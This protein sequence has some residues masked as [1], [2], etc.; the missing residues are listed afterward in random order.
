MNIDQ[1]VCSATA[2]GSIELRWELR[3]PVQVTDEMMIFGL[4]PFG[5]EFDYVADRNDSHEPIIID[6]GHLGNVPVAHLRHDFLDIIA[7]FAP[8]GIPGHDF[9]N[10]HGAKRF[11]LDMKPTKDVTLAEDPK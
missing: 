5:H 2:L 8:D 3:I 11:A 6:N 4:E 10:L 7:R 9:G 1:D